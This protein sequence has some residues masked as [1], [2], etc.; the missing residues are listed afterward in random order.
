VPL[1][2]WLSIL[3]L[4]VRSL[5][6]GGELDRE[7][8]RAVTLVALGVLAGT[9]LSMLAARFVT[10]LLYDVA[11]RDPATLVFAALVLGATGRF[12]AWLPARRAA[13]TDPAN[14]LRDL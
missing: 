11:P 4:R 10:S 6:R 12:A 13:R 2:R 14:V 1:E 5:V 7:L 3:H 8:G 9:T